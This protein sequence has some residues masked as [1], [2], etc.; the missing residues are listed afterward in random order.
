LPRARH[1]IDDVERARRNAAVDHRLGEKKCRRRLGVPF[2]VVGAASRLGERVA[3]EFVLFERLLG[4]DFFGAFADQ[5]G[6]FCA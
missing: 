4:R 5:R 3:I 1:T 6:A 2:D